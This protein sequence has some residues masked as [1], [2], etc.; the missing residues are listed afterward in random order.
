MAT[1]NFHSVLIGYLGIKEKIIFNLT[2]KSWSYGLGQNRWLCLSVIQKTEFLTQVFGESPSGS[3]MPKLSPL[4]K[5][6]Y[7]LNVHGI[8][9]TMFSGKYAR[10]VKKI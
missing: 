2:E 1:K 8:L 4:G 7:Y 3:S 6:F 5:E 10:N 9:G